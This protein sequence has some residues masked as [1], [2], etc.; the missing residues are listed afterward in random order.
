M[1]VGLTKPHL[2]FVSPKKY[3]DLYDM[4]DFKVPF[5]GA[6]I[7]NNNYSLAP[8]NELRAYRDMPKEGFLDDENSL[9]LI[10]GYHASISYMDAQVGKVM[11][12]LERLDLRKNTVVILLGDHGWKIG[13]YGAWCKH[14][15]S[16]IDAN[17]PFIVSRETSY[18]DRKSGVESDALIEA[19]DL[20]PTMVDL[21]G[22]DIDGK[23]GKSI[24]PL[25][26]KPKMKWDEAAYSLY[27]RGKDVM[28]FSCTDGEFRYTEWWDNVNSKVLYTE[29]YTCEQ[30]YTK[31]MYNLADQPKYSKSVESM[32]LLLD[33]QFSTDRRSS[34]PQYDK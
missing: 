24:V 5:K 34:Y 18:A 25:T 17:I 6:P 29:L 16:E 27:P 14:S 26:D 33:K 9:R 20:F 32:K 8:W 31:Q 7:G 10:H 19:V 22:L 4:D 13:E 21:C 23:D 28:G 30:D 2:P 12:E 15:N 1:F 3:W 11:A